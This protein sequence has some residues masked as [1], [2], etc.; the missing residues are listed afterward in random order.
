VVYEDVCIKN[1]KNPIYMDSDY[2]HF[3]KQGDRL[4]WFTGVT[5]KN[6][7]ILTGGKIT[8]QGFD[9]K[10]PLG[11][12]FDNVWFD[13]LPDTKVTAEHATLNFVSTN[14]KVTGEGVVISGSSTPTPNSCEGKFVPMPQ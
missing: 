9:E 2:A 3:G 12:T 4:P 1:T 13:S 5:L 10:H 11:M 8:L 6:V 14:L 7:R